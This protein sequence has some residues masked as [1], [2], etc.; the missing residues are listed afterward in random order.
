M[1]EIILLGFE[2]CCG[3]VVDSDGGDFVAHAIV[4]AA[5]LAS[6]VF[7]HDFCGNVETVRNLAKYRVAVVEEWGGSGGDEELRAIGARAGVGHGKHSGR[8]MAEIGV[9]FI[10][11]FVSRAAASCF[12]GI[13]ALQHKALDDAV[14]GHAIVV[15]TSCEI[16]EIRTCEWCFG[17]VESGGDVSCRGVDGDF[18]IGHSR[19]QH[20]WL[21][22]GNHTIINL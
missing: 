14:E 4:F 9:E 18:D 8:A 3:V 6:I 13:T 5:A 2:Q 10:G 20:A 7:A 22:G 11:E 16:Q 21:G 15:S 1:F 19:R 17:G 12:C